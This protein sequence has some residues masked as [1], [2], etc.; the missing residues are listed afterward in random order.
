MKKETKEHKE[1]L[2]EEKIKDKEAAM[3]R[4]SIK[5]VKNVKKVRTG[6]IN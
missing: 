5:K 2:Q 1:Y 6:V 3:I 4:K